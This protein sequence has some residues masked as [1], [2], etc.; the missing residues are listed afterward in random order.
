[1]YT[2]RPVAIVSMSL[3]S[4]RSSNSIIS[5]RYYAI[6]STMASQLTLPRTASCPHAPFQLQSEPQP[7]SDAVER[8]VRLVFA[9]GRFPHSLLP[10]VLFLPL[11]RSV[12]ALHSSWLWGAQRR[13]LLSL[14]SVFVTSHSLSPLA[15]VFPFRLPRHALVP[16]GCE[17]L[18]GGGCCRCGVP[19][20]G[21]LFFLCAASPEFPI[22][23]FRV[24][25]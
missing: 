22:V 23:S 5:Y 10:L 20:W 17:G 1:M 25:A 8:R 21:F 14:Q 16:H 15:L 12:L 18:R 3:I 4:P 7:G 2:P 11:R 13:Q 24:R 19:L 6:P 9:S